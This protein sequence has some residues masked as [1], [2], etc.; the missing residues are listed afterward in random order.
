MPCSLSSV[1]SRA[2]TLLALV[3]ALLAS[4]GVTAP[5]ASAATTGSRVVAEAAK[6]QGA[7]YKYGATGPTRFDCSGYTRYVYSR[8]GKSLPHSS[9]QQYSRTHHVAKS[10]KQ[11]GDLI[12]FKS[13]SSITH[14]GIY[15]GS[16]TMWDAP[17][18]GDVVKHRK[19]YS[20]NYVVG[21][22]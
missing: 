7:P 19:I 11:V 13:G 17:K 18:S 4:L 1:S 9:S 2:L 6:H 20:S 5:H 16:G 15:A 10:S 14:V 21:R 22:P 8:F 3:V 12:F